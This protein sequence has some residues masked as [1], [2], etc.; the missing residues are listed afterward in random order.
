MS[1]AAITSPKFVRERDL[2][3]RLVRRLALSVES[4]QDPNTTGPETGADVTIIRGRQRIGVQVTI[5][6]TGAVPGKAIAAEKA[7]A[8]AAL[9]GGG[10]GVYAGW[11]NPVPMDAIV[12]AITKKAR[13]RVAGFDE[14]WLL[15]SAGIPEHGATIATSLMTQWLTPEALTA[16]TAGLLARSSYRRAFLHPIIALEDAL[17]EWTRAGHWTKDVRPRPGPEGPSFW[18]IQR[19][20][21]RR[22]PF[23]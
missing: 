17:Y 11:G 14:V 1:S 9:E 20:M 5:L 2:V 10:T 23:Q 22:S 21:K 13:A 16:A 6:D 18:D 4:Y 12:A 7:Q 8:K 3:E 19:K 15:V